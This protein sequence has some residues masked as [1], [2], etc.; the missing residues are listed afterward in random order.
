MLIEIPISSIVLEERQRRDYG[1][2]SK[3]AESIKK[4]GQMQN[5]LVHRRENGTFRLIA[6][7]R[8]LAGLIA[9]GKTL[10]IAKVQSEGEEDELL[11]QELELEEN[12]NRKNL[13]WIEEQKAIAKMHE[14]RQARAKKEGKEWTVDNTANLVGMAKRSIYNAIELT[15]AVQEHPDVASADTAFGAMQRL[16]RIKDLKKRQDDVAVRALAVETGQAKPITA[17]VF[18][19]DAVD[20]MKQVPDESQDYVITNPPFGVDIEEIFT[21]DK[22][23]YADDEDMVRELCRKTFIEAYRVLKPDRWFVTFY[24][25]LRLEECRTF[26]AEAGFKFQRVPAI[27]VKPNKYMS[28][29]NDPYVQLGIRY[30][31]FFFARKGNAKFHQLPKNGNVFVF[32]TPGVNRIHPLQMPPE[33]WDEIFGLIS[34][35]G[36]VG[37]EPFAGSGSGGVA[38]I[39]RQL[40]YKGFELNPEF[41]ARANTWLSEVANGNSE[42]PISGITFDEVPF[43]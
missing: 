33:L 31:S 40:Q 14:I 30:E 26:L 27:W 37:V 15:K 4:N 22:T 1:D 29:V 35:G 38:A 43:E 5:L 6:G 16:N 34:I 7:G 20:L 28:S 41:V 8:R 25:T 36:E 9:A 18:Q 2:L 19:G 23:I 17:Q 11:M 3:L 13:E 21:A 42:A 24:P 39:K 12:V 10:A 32:D